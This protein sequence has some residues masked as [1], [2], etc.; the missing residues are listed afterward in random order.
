M[1]IKVLIPLH[2]LQNPLVKLIFFLG[3][4]V[5]LSQLL[6]FH[7]IPQ[8]LHLHIHLLIIL[9]AYVKILHQFNVLYCRILLSIIYIYILLIAYFFTILNHFFSTFIIKIFSQFHYYFLVMNN[10]Q[11]IM[12]LITTV[13]GV[14]ALPKTF[15]NSLQFFY[16]DNSESSFRKAII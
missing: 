11:Y 5:L 14:N 1:F 12:F 15:L 3:C 9:F 10:Y 7:R 16:K 6:H 4:F 8:I 2:Y 13:L